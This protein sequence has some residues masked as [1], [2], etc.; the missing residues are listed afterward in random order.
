MSARLMKILVFVMAM[1]PSVVLGQVYAPEGINMPG[2]WNGWTNSNDAQTMGNF[3]MSHRDFGGGQ[4]VSRI[5]IA[6]AG[7]DATA[8]KYE[9]LFSS[10]PETSAFDNKWAGA[11][12]TV[13]GISTLTL[14]S[15]TNNTITVQN[16]N[17][18]TF[19]FDDNGY[20]NTDVS[21]LKTSAE[22]ITITSVSGIPQNI[23]AEN[24]PVTITVE[25]D[26]PKSPEE[27]VYL[28]YST[29]SFSTSDAV[30]IT[31]F[32]EGTS[33]TAIIPG[34]AKNRKVEFYV[35]STTVSEAAWNNRVDLLT[36]NQET[37]GGTNFS[38]AYEA[39]IFPKNEATEVSRTPEIT[40]FST[41][42]LTGYDLM[43]ADNAS[44]TNPSVDEQ[45]ISDTTYTVTTALTPSTK[46]YWKFKAD[47]ASDWSRVFNFNTVSAILYANV[48]FPKSVVMEQGES[49][50][51]FGQVYAQGVTEAEG[52]PQN[53]RAWVGVNGSNSNPENWGESSWNVATYNSSPDTSIIG[54]NDE[55][56]AT[57]GTGLSPGSY[58]Y[59]YRFQYKTQDFE[60]GVLGGIW[61]DTTQILGQLQVLELP[62][63]ALPLDQVTDVSL[64]PEFSWTASDAAIK[65]YQVQVSETSAFQN[66]VL[67]DENTIAKNLQISSGSLT[68]NTTY[69]WR[70]KSVYDTTATGWT[71]A[72]SFT[73]LQNK[74]GKI[75]LSQPADALDGVSLTPVFNWQN[76]A[77]ATSYQLQVSAS[78]HFNS[79]NID[80]PQIT[81]T[82]FEV[83]E[84]SKLDDVSTYFW[85]VRG[86]NGRGSGIWSDTFLFTTQIPGVQ[87]A[88]PADG[89]TAIS[90]SPLL[91]WN[92]VAGAQSYEVQLASQLSFS[93]P[94]I[95]SSAIT[96]TVLQVGEP[97][98]NSTEYFW[99]VRVQKNGMK[100][101]WSAPF[102]FKTKIS[103][104]NQVTLSAPGNNSEDI[105]TRPILKWEKSNR[106]ASY[107]LQL[108][109]DSLFSTFAIHE[110][111]L[112]A[113]QYS[114][115]PAQAL[116]LATDYYWR[117]RGVN[118]SGVGNWSDVSSFTTEIP[119]PELHLPAKNAT[120]VPVN[121]MLNWYKNLGAQSYDIQ[122][123]SN[124]GF[125][126]LALDTAAVSDTSLLAQN[127]NYNTTYYW[128]SRLTI[129]Q[130]KS[131]WSAPFTFT[132]RAT[133]PAYPV[134]SSPESGAINVDLSPE[135]SWAS[136]TGAVSY[137]IEVATQSDFQ[138]EIVLDTAGYTQT[139][140]PLEALSRNA[141]YFWRVRA[142]NT[143]GSYGQWSTVGAF[144]TIPTPPSAPVLLAPVDDEKDLGS[145]LAFIWQ[146]Q[147]DAN[148]Y[149]FQYS[150]SAT[151]TFSYDTVLTDTAL[152]LSSFNSGETYFWRV[153]S[154]N[155]GGNSSWS[156]THEFGTGVSG[157]PGP[158]LQYPKDDFTNAETTFDLK[159]AED[160]AAN[161][162]QI[163]LAT[164]S[165]FSSLLVDTSGVIQTS[166]TLSELR[167]QQSYFWRI[168][169]EDSKGNSTWSEVFSFTTKASKLN[170]VV[171][172][173]PVDSLLDVGTPAIFTWN[174]IPEAD[175]YEISIAKNKNF[176]FATDSVLID[177]TLTL[178]ELKSGTG[179]YWRVRTQSEGGFS[180][181][182]AVHYF[183][184][185][186]SGYPGPELQY[187][188]DRFSNAETT[189]D[190]SWMEDKVASSYQVQ[191]SDS[192]QF[193]SFIIDTSGVSQTTFTLA[194]LQHLHRYYWR[195]RSEDSRGNSD[196]SDAFSF[197]IRDAAP[198]EVTLLSPADSTQ[199]VNL[200]VSFK[201]S[202][203]AN[204]SSYQI[205][206]STTQKFSISIDSTVT[207]TS[208]KLHRL[209][210]DQAYYWKVRAV[211][212]TGTSRW[213]GAGYFT[214]NIEVPGIPELINPEDEEMR[215]STVNFGW[216]KTPRTAHYS[217]QVTE[218]ATF[219]DLV[220]DST[221]IVGVSLKAENLEEA[222]TYYWRVRGEN[223]A[224]YGSWSDTLSFTMEQ[225]TSNELEAI[226]TEFA[227]RQ[228]Y[229][230]PFNP[231]TNIQYDIKQAEAVKIQI[232]DISGRLIQTLV[233]SQKQAGRYTVTF[234]AGSLASGVYLMRMQTESFLKIRKMMLIK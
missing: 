203:I 143:Q 159:W 47:T 24:V 142:S 84:L 211:N 157:Y 162:Y 207:D 144:T 62:E 224:G 51:V 93:N 106:A 228:N 113:V 23:V 181:W 179:Y 168:R 141:T 64:T 43:L 11:I 52:E 33:G 206:I 46:F 130:K 97:L 201:W 21:V 175:S 9:M 148:S 34:Q 231:T 188:K 98:D 14:G 213:S 56:E 80:E 191:V 104:P 72:R 20:A 18:Y 6:A 112:T 5:H 17:Y 78:S 184:T 94:I 2:E 53:M 185:G 48:Q 3:R 210:S 202:Q 102:S 145:I 196:W 79:F 158:E 138:S 117:V 212:K 95:S 41:E 192:A 167:H 194:G 16:D 221:H 209:N 149:R 39:N 66:P 198:D 8:G 12:V 172:L 178:P 57:I 229:P 176:D 19:I 193:S 15:A 215:T 225:L 170:Q 182:S 29:D 217:L 60:Y 214:T 200:P 37:N 63:L 101:D 208:L 61:D 89:D 189:L 114:P 150:T 122:V 103:V 111:G 195:V 69:F 131:D 70:V 27:K 42:H 146:S 216:N 75:T 82:Q 68:Y 205:K 110:S 155:T 32:G 154:V 234:D 153:R 55:Y 222:T 26:K 85:R 81:A 71:E 108:S 10:G 183:E 65:E 165:K 132:T 58:Y 119:I 105:A 91:K 164:S 77:S 54:N 107:E 232:F 67:L 160:K 187:P 129:N 45:S 127:L 233:D 123:A 22:P 174:S 136:S 218:T 74:P 73:T 13:D 96:D 50:T 115:T 125:M 133:P 1:A 227:L 139:Y 152:S 36:L 186:V 4:Y 171:L 197:T 230:N 166:F 151:F 88:T 86:V 87:L 120:L 156:Q 219:E 180:D 173:S 92:Q 109:E 190:V 31:N 100:S 121:P 118:S 38:Y 163:Q 137:H 126:N 90:V 7:G 25:I 204:A 199:D 49:T 124:V 134:L 35:L 30:E 177:T 116:D 161:S 128:R 223:R 147:L 169:S 135:L 226:P 76:E 40:W 140:L 99:R 220:I 59:A 83:P 28:R 44:F